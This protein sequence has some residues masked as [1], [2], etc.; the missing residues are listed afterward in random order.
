MLPSQ[1]ENRRPEDQPRPHAEKEIGRVK[2]KATYSDHCFTV[3]GILRECDVESAFTFRAPQTLLVEGPG[4]DSPA[5]CEEGKDQKLPDSWQHMS[6]LLPSISKG[7][8]PRQTAPPPLSSPR[9]AP[10]MIM[11]GVHQGKT[12]LLY[13]KGLAEEDSVFDGESRFASWWH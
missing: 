10:H 5:L 6:D 3:N 12:G 1:G 7:S 9:S 4:R 8:P 11:D 13:V 2:W